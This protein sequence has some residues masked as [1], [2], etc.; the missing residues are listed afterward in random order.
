MNNIAATQ[1]QIT[2]RG[3]TPPKFTIAMAET[4]MDL[5]FIYC[6]AAI[7]ARKHRWRHL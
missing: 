6:M 2:Y 7:L 1:M 5:D 4:Y 3:T